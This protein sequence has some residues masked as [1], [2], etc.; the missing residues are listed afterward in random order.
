MFVKVNTLAAIRDYFVSGLED[1]Y[2]SSEA[3]IL[4]ESTCEHFLGWSKLEQKTKLDARL[5]ESE[6]LD[7][8]FTLKRLKTKEPIQYILESAPFFGLEFKVSNNVL[9]PRPETEE[10][11][12]YVIKNSSINARIIDF[13]T[14]SGCIP[15]TIKHK[16]P[17]ARVY[18]V[19]I[20]NEALE[21]A[22]LNALSLNTEVKF[23]Q[24]DILNDKKLA[25]SFP[26]QFDIIVSNPPYVRHS[27]KLKMEAN[28][29]AYE[30]H[31]ALF[32][33]DEDPLI[34]YRKIGEMGRNLLSKNGQIFF[35]INQ[36]LATD[37][38][39]LI[40]SLGYSE[41]SILSDIN[42]NPRILHAKI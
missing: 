10:L 28:V 35:E 38:Q 11:V 19:D 13:G 9:I 36:Y 1:I 6:L 5:S 33:E 34:F 14:G 8:H 27:E 18:A 22:K 32:V 4:F 30:P 2:T 20:S 16:R 12:D 15:V 25:N 23:D 41:V 21:I 7:F 40:E 37:T 39:S 3:I 17:D 31:L 24:F 42:N 26:E 29:L